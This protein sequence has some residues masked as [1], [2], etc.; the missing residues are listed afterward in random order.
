MSIAAIVRKMVEAGAS[1]EVIALAIE[2]I[3]SAQLEKSKS[4]RSERNRRYYEKR[5]NKTSES[6]LNGVLDASETVLKASENPA[7][8]VCEPAHVLNLEELSIYP[9]TEPTVLTPKPENTLPSTQAG[10]PQPAKETRKSKRTD[11]AEA[12]RAELATALDAER[13]EAVYRYRIAKGVA[14]TTYAVRLLIAEMVKTGCPNEAADE[15]IRNDWRGFKLEW[16]DRVRAA[17][18]PARAGPNGSH[19]PKT[20]LRMDVTIESIADER[21]GITV[22]RSLFAP[23]A[24]PDVAPA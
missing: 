15:M 23:G 7:P 10:T 24:D 20:N 22:D 9:L 11:S 16:W 13:S 19:A 5:L 6:V 21:A 2:A 18:P 1:A 4:A 17:R 3:E 8:R 14:Q 12:I